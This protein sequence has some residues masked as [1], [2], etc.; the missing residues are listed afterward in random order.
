M[1]KDHCWRSSI[2]CSIP[3]GWWDAYYQT[4]SRLDARCMPCIISRL[5]RL[6]PKAGPSVTEAAKWW[7]VIKEP[8]AHATWQMLFSYLHFTAHNLAAMESPFGVKTAQGELAS[9]GPGSP[10]ATT[11]W[12][13]SI[14]RILYEDSLASMRTFTQWCDEFVYLYQLQEWYVCTVRKIGYQVVFTC[15]TAGVEL[16]AQYILIAFHR[17][18]HRNVCSRRG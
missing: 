4:L 17:I 16:F 14:M 3:S 5:R 9:G 7:Y 2:Y 6:A 1:P 13:L 8:G 18:M 15:C 10:K 12:S 11:T